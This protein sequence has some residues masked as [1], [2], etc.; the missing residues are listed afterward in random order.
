MNLSSASVHGKGRAI[1]PPFQGLIWKGV[2]GIEEISKI[3]GLLLELGQVH[4]VE[5]RNIHAA[6]SMTCIID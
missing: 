6:E 4:E 5:A 2:E 3:K 1:W